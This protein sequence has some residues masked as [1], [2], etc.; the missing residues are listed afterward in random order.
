MGYSMPGFPVLHHLPELAQTQVHWSGDT[1]QP[2][3]SSSPPVLNLSQHQSFLRVSSSHQ[4]VKVLELQFQHQSFQR[5][6]RIDFFRIDWFD[7]LA[8]QGI[9]KSLFQHHSLESPVLRCSAFFTV[10][11]SYPYMATGWNYS[12]GYTDLHWQSNV[13]AF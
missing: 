10:Q 9:L 3:S 6:F 11:F 2:L 12:F 7:L 13:S 1:I 5:I 8:V 4:V